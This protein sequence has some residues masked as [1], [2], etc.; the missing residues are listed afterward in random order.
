[1]IYNL[2]GTVRAK[3]FGRV[4][5]KSGAWHNGMTALNHIIL[6]CIDGTIR[7]KMGNE[8]FQAEAKDLLLIPQHTFYKPLDGGPCRYYFFHFTAPVL[9]ANESMPSRAVI[10]PHT[11]LVDGY[12]Y[13][14]T[15]QYPSLVTVQTHIKN[16]PYAIKD[17][18]TQAE[19]LKP[20]ANFS[21]QLLLDHL[22]RELLI[23]TEKANAP[24]HSKQLTAMLTYIAQHYAEKLSLTVL[25]EHFLLSQSYIARLFKKELGQKPSEYINGVRISIAK[26]MLTETNLNITEI[27]EKTGFASVYYFSKVFKQ[28][29]GHAPSSL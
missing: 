10:A 2:D 29:T 23:C 26:T 25:S 24:Q 3:M 13:T 20:N 12:A 17:L 14:C 15:S 27:A 18:F 9:S 6:Y 8:V 5:Q 22:L 28:I 1:M 11:G 7:M 4:S 16:A 21:D 19:K